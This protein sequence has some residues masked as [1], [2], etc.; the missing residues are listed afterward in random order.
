MRKTPRAN[1]R[2][3]SRSD[4]DVELVGILQ[5][6]IQVDMLCCIRGCIIPLCFV[7][8][9]VVCPNSVL[10]YLPNVIFHYM[11]GAKTQ[12]TQIIQRDA[13]V[14][15]GMPEWSHF[16]FITMAKSLPTLAHQCTW[17]AET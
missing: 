16:A 11:L 17:R 3:S 7:V 14:I 1:A 10:A 15:T 4:S 2:K 8:R 5:G 6:D 12:E 13:F 9:F